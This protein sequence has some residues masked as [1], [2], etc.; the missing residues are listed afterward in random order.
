MLSKDINFEH[1]E[2]IPAKFFIFETLKFDITMDV[3]D[4]QSLNI[5]SNL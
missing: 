4:L 1:P 2:N 5:Y 3:R